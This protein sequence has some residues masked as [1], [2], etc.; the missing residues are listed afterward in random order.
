MGRGWGELVPAGAFEEPRLQ[1]PAQ[2]AASRPAWCVPG[3][4]A[5]SL[6]GLEQLS[7]RFLPQQTP[8]L[9]LRD[10]LLCWDEVF[11]WE[12][13]GVGIRV[14]AGMMGAPAPPAHACLSPSLFFPL[15]LER[16]ETS[17]I[18]Q[19]LLSETLD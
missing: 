19:P 12:C 6:G 2:L 3:G 11:W 13:P 5:G 15:W 17:L 18:S 9:P 14:G 1:P 16:A 4:L 7:Q 10:C 8:C